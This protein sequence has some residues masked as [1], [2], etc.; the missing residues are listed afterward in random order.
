MTRVDAKTTVPPFASFTFHTPS[1]SYASQLHTTPKKTSTDCGRGLGDT[2]RA[3]NVNAAN[4]GAADT[5]LLLR[6][7][8][9]IPA[10][11]HM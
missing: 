10:N 2:Q 11:R 4:L 1:S 8:G 9:R 6:G 3:Q 7:Y 5:A